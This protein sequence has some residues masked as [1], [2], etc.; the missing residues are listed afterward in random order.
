MDGQ[1]YGTN[2]WMNGST[3]RERDGWIDGHMNKWVDGQ[4]DGRMGGWMSRCYIAHS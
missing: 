1:T 4:M 2:G 3:G